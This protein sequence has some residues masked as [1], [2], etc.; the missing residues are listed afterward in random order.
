MQGRWKACEWVCELYA[1]VYANDT[2]LNMNAAN[3]YEIVLG[4][5]FYFVG[6]FFVNVRLSIK[7]I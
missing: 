3:F 5:I 7:F 1:N 2:N 4:V 6:S